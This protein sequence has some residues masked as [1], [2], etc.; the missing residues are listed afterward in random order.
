MESAMAGEPHDEMSETPE[1][2]SSTLFDLRYLIGALFALYGVVLVVASPFVDD[3]KAGGIDMNL[4]LG[5]GMLGLGVFFLGWA[6]A[7]PLKVAGESAR[8][9]AEHEARD[10]HEG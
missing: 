4:W 2:A 9:R 1:G 6:R 10:R 3:T 5:L 7:R 8:A